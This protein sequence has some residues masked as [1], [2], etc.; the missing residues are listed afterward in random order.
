MC[1]HIS[2]QDFCRTVYTRVDAWYKYCINILIYLD[3][4]SRNTSDVRHAVSVE[5]LVCI[6]GTVLGMVMNLWLCSKITRA[7]FIIIL[8]SFIPIQFRG[9]WPSGRKE[10]GGRPSL[11]SAS[12][13]QTY[14][15]SGMCNTAEHP[16]GPMN[17]TNIWA[18]WVNVKHILL[19][20][21][22]TSQ[23]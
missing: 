14:D 15:W 4:T 3:C 2:E 19:R 13:L 17:A 21:T 5:H 7:I 11:S 1:S 10:Q 12:N 16:A 22:P 6:T 18:L 23:Y 9:P 20:F 8:A